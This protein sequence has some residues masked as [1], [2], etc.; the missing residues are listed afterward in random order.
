MER[1]GQPMAMNSADLKLIEAIHRAPG[2][3]VLALT[4]GGAGA[5]AMLLGVPGA[6][7]TVLEVV[8]PYG[9][10][11][12]ADFLG[13]RP[14]QFCSAATAAAMAERAHARARWLAPGEDVVGL[15]CTASLV[16]DRPKQGD[17]RFHV[18]FRTY[19]HPTIYSVRL[20]KGARDRAGEEEVLDSF[21]LLALASA[22]RLPEPECLPLLPE[23][24]LETGEFEYLSTLDCFLAGGATAAFVTPHG[25]VIAPR[26][27]SVLIPGSFNPLHEGHLQLAAAVGQIA[28]CDRAYSAPAFELSVTNVDKPPLSNEEV[29]RRVEQLAWKAP[30]WVTRAPTFLEKATVF[31]GVIFAVGVDT[32]ARIVDPR[33]YGNSEAAMAEALAGFRDKG[34]RFLVAGRADASG[35]FLELRDLAVPPV[36]ADLF[37][38]IPE[39][40]FRADVSS[41]HLRCRT[42]ES[43]GSG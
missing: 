12:L 25:Q 34:C 17:H 7:R 6:S 33:Y 42:I 28:Q 18:A 19:A 5:T 15:G 10:R 29:R 8:V 11:A 31:P 14:E 21:I 40:R 23:E 4:G 20:Q 2:K 39:H 1:R 9:E 26:R 35:R 32:A 37:E 38:P 22:F 36:F 43:E 13:R 16:T 30:V 27:P 41:T 3:C 24:I